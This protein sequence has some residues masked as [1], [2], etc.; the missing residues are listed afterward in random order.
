MQL[1]ACLGRSLAGKERPL[2]ASR[3]RQTGF[4]GAQQNADVASGF[5]HGCKTRLQTV[6]QILMFSLPRQRAS[7]Q[8]FAPGG[9]RF[10]S[11]AMPM[12][13]LGPI[14]FQLPADAA[15]RGNGRR[16]VAPR[17][18]QALLHFADDVRQQRLRVLDLI[19][20]R[21]EVCGDDVG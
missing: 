13:H 20:Q 8:V 6:N 7:G 14:L 16:R 18:G 19:E 11:L 5:G 3:L 12:L 1:N 21:M 17:R 10:T 9:Q 4:Q 2:L 15:L